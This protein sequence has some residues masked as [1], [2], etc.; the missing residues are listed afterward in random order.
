[1]RE[2]TRTSEGSLSCAFLEAIQPLLS[3]KLAATTLVLGVVLPFR[4]GS[5]KVQTSPDVKVIVDQVERVE[6][7]DVELHIAVRN[8]AGHDIYLP[9]YGTGGEPAEQIRT[10]TVYQRVAGDGWRRLGAESE[11]PLS[12][13]TRLGPGKVLTLVRWVQDPALALRPGEG[14]PAFKGE[15][16]PLAGKHKITL[17]YFASEKEWLN[18]RKHVEGRSGKT[19]GKW[20][21]GSPAPMRVAESEEFEIPPANT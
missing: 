18:Y 4:A 2:T 11:L 7:K 15:L 1:M 20:K 9:I 21:P 16:V 13:V 8:E 6:P 3:I 19:V 10:V 17:A 14:V 12:A 5:S